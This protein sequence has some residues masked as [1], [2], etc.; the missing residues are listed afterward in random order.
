MSK[1]KVTMSATQ[2]TEKWAQRLKGAIPEIQA[3]IDAVTE[4]PAEKAIAKKDKML[5]NITAA[6]QN[7]AWENGLK[8]VNLS[9]WKQKTKEKVAQRMSGGVDAAKSKHQQFANWLVQTQNAILPQI[10][11]MPDQ[12]LEDNI[13][14]SAA[15]QRAMAA[16]KYKANN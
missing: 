5:R 6:V 2:I 1:T 8:K 12:T 10:N 15:M 3:G 13:Q 7:G 16:N 4:S 11:A 9:D 14:R